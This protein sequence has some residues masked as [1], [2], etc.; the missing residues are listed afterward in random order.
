MK[1]SPFTLSFFQEAIRGNGV[2]P[3]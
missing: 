3:R 1:T 2:G